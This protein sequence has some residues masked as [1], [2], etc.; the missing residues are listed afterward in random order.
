M[1]MDVKSWKTFCLR[2]FRSLLMIYAVTFLALTFFQR[3]LIYFPPHFTSEEVDTTARELRLERWRDSSGQAIGMMRM[4]P[5]QPAAAQVLIAYGNGG[6]ATDCAVYADELQKLAA[7]DVFILEYPG[8]ADRPGTPTEKNIFRAADQALQRLPANRPVYLLG[9]SLGSGVAAYLAGAQPDR[10]AG[11]ILL[12]P[13]DRAASVGQYRFPIFPVRWLLLDQFAS[14]DY[15]RRY[16]GPV[17]VMV[18]GRDLVV[19]ERFGLK[20][21]DGY[22]GP[23]R[24]W[25]FARGTHITIMGPPA[26]FWTAVLEFWKTN[27]PAAR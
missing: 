26:Q 17:G 11:M 1:K 21:Y 15:L 23:K 20:L 2:V 12:S 18:D 27:A 22:A 4:S 5:R 7:L 8:Y 25:Q 3:R 13:Y 6:C 14:E 9:E 16:H 10:I 19:P 24:L